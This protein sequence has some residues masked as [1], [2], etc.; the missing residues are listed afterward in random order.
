MN[1]NEL[2]DCAETGNLEGVK[3]LVE[4]GANIDET[5]DQWTDNEGMTALMLAIRSGKFEIVVYLVEHGANVA[6]TDSEGMTALLWV[7]DEEDITAVKYLLEHGASLT[8]SSNDG[9]TALLRAASGGRLQ[10]V[11]YLHSLECSASITETD[12]SGNTALLRAAMYHNP[13]VVQ[14]L[15]EYGNAQ[16]TDT[17]SVGDL[18]WT[19][20]YGLPVM[21]KRAYAESNDGRFPTYKGDHVREGDIVA[22]AAMLHVMVLHSEPP[23]SL[24]NALAPPFQRIVRDGARLRARLPAYLAGR[25]ALLDTNCPLLLPLQALVHGYKEP[26]TTDELWATGLGASLHRAKRSRPERGQSL[27]HRYARVVRQ[28]WL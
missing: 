4:G 11:R 10:L 26:T 20:G 19:E 15:L 16:I 21:L 6:H 3:Q 22:F 23:E 24:T 8:E 9:T 28:K 25:R 7:C 5:D 17:N 13:K 18:V 2:H 1:V 27:E 12:G 14:W